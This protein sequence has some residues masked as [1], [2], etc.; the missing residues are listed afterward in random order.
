KVKKEVEIHFKKQFSRRNYEGL[1]TAITEEEWEIA[2]DQTKT[3]SA[4]DASGILYP[5][6]KNCS[7]RT[8]E[9]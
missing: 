2:M 9:T 8:K 3:N 4:P 1:M 7:N 5:L 6:L